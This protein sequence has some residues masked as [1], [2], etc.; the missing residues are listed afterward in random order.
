LG[1][2]AAFNTVWPPLF[3]EISNQARLKSPGFEGGNLD[4]PEP[5]DASSK[6]VL[7]PC[8]D[9][10][11]RLGSALQING[12]FF[13]SVGINRHH[14]K[15][16]ITNLQ[17]SHLIASQDSKIIAAKILEPSTGVHSRPLDLE[18]NYT[19]CGKSYQ[20]L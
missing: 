17:G 3:S 20:G 19:V 10:S 9:F 6:H 5:G 8:A 11:S 14:N 7:H 16:H 1:I 12:L 13:W 15:T 4:R 18:G 2:A